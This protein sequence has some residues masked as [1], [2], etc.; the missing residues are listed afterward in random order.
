[1]N[2]TF[3]VDETAAHLLLRVWNLNRGT[4]V[5]YLLISFKCNHKALFLVHALQIRSV[6]ASKNAA[7]SSL[8]KISKQISN[9]DIFCNQHLITASVFKHSYVNMS[10]LI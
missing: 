9:N 3:C 6:L 2:V 10:S 7:T 1:M 5:F 8:L 4:K